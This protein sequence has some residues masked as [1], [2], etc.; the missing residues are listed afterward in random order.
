MQ[1]FFSAEPV[2]LSWGIALV[3]VITGAFLIFHGWECFDAEKMKMY[4]GWFADRHYANRKSVAL[5]S[6]DR[7]SV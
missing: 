6:L 7:K 3:R 2:R 5:F 4:A 1:R